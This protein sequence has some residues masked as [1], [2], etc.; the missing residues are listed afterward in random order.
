[1]PL[2]DEIIDDTRKARCLLLK[3]QKL[4][5]EKA[6]LAR[7]LLE[8][9]ITKPQAQETIVNAF[10]QEEVP[11]ADAQL[12]VRGWTGRSAALAAEA[13]GDQGH[14]RQQQELRRRVA[15]AASLVGHGR[16]QPD[17]D[18][19]RRQLMEARKRARAANAEDERRSASAAL[20]GTTLL[21]ATT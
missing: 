7:T 3:K 2:N 8:N 18:D 9:A 19:A 17:G 13:S 12:G 10:G 16:G 5:E 11:R 21:A 15:R 1:M 6:T 14:V 20:Y 4:R